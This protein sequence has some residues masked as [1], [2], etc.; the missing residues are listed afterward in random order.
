MSASQQLL[1][2]LLL[3]FL[4]VA[5]SIYRLAQLS[6][7]PMASHRLLMLSQLQWY[8]HR[9]SGDCMLPLRRLWA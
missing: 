1:L 4:A 6:G 8:C 7:Y 9:G 2:L 5:L 3:L